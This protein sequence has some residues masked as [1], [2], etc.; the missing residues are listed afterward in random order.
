LTAHTGDITDS[1]VTV[2]ANASPTTVTGNITGAGAFAANTLNRRPDFRRGNLLKRGTGTLTLNSGNN[3]AY[4]GETTVAGGKIVL[5]STTNFA[6]QALNLVSGVAFEDAAGYHWN[7]LAVTG[8]TSPATYT[9]TLDV[10][11]ANLNFLIPEGMGAGS[12]LLN[13]TG[14]A[15]IGGSTFNVAIAGG[16]PALQ[17]GQSVNLISATGG[18]NGS[19][20]N[21]ASMNYGPTTGTQ[22]SLIAYAFD[23]HNDGNSL[24]ATVAG[25][26]IREESKSLLEGHLSGMAALSRAGLGGSGLQP[27]LAHG[28]GRLRY[29]TGS[30][31]ESQGYNFLAGAVAGF[32]AAAGE[33]LAGAF[34]EYGK[35]EYDTY[36]AFPVGEV[37][38]DGNTHTAAWASLA[39]WI[40]RTASTSKA[41]SAG[42]RSTPSTS[43]TSCA[44]SSAP[45]PP[46]PPRPPT[47]AHTSAAASAGRSP[48]NSAWRPMASSSGRARTATR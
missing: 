25:A 15:N 19:P 24:K 26:R 33:A 27:F 31:I 29:E 43:R 8:G 22:G 10:T 14:A 48:E 18:G 6:S 44:T 23:L 12:T 30:H 9:G 7:K 41:A 28:G 46:T 21:A 32:R 34:F 45:A 1:T 17:M 39:A 40:S 3:A 36:N 11:N 13:V 16:A 47:P 2:N 35:G 42:A 20:A 5:S 4:T 38:G 37:K